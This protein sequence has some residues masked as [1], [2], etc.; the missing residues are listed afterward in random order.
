MVALVRE[1]RAE[2]VLLQ[3]SNGARRDVDSR[4]QYPGAECL[5]LLVVKDQH[6]AETPDPARAQ[7]HNESPARPK[8]A[9]SAAKCATDNDRPEPGEDEYD[10]RSE[11]N[12]RVREALSQEHEMRRASAWRDRDRMRSTPQ[13]DADR[14]RAA[15]AKCDV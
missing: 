12:H 13:S 10:N 1:D 8:L 6:V 5:R 11:V 9:P 2:L 3:Q 15:D 14:D 7:R 4:S